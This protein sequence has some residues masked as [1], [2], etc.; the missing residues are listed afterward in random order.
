MMATRILDP[1][2]AFPTSIPASGIA[3]RTRTKTTG[4]LAAKG[5]STTG[6]CTIGSSIGTSKAV[7][8]K[9]RESEPPLPHS[10]RPAA[11]IPLQHPGNLSALATRRSVTPS[12]AGI[13][14]SATHSET[15]DPGPQRLQISRPSASTSSLVETTPQLHTMKTRVA[16]RDKSPHRF[17]IVPLKE[18]GSKREQVE[19]LK[20]GGIKKETKMV[21]GEQ[22]NA[23]KEN[24]VRELSLAVA[25]SSRNARSSGISPAIDSVRPDPQLQLIPIRSLNIVKLP[26]KWTSRSGA[27][28]VKTSSMQVTRTF[29]SEASTYFASSAKDSG[30]RT[31]TL[32]ERDPNIPGLSTLIN[33]HTRSSTAHQPFTAPNHE[34]PPNYSSC[35][36]CKP[37]HTPSKG[38]TPPRSSP[39]CKSSSLGVVQRPVWSISMTSPD[40]PR[41][42]VDSSAPKLAPSGKGHT[43]L[44]A[45]AAAI[46]RRHRHATAYSVD[47]LNPGGGSNITKFSP[48]RSSC[49]IVTTSRQ[50]P[51]VRKIFGAPLE[52]H[53]EKDEGEDDSATQALK[54]QSTSKRHAI[55]SRSMITTSPSSQLKNT[56]SITSALPPAFIPSANSG[57]FDSILRAYQ[58][59]SINTNH[60]SLNLVGLRS[61]ARSALVVPLALCKNRPGTCDSGALPG[62]AL[63]HLPIIQELLHAVDS[64]LQDWNALKPM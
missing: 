55:Y 28:K 30:R 51:D 36:P 26:A 62:R 45:A 47:A 11:K 54:R 37:P 15:I 13:P 23:G 60:S 33:K 38:A 48:S 7:R 53:T 31:R 12:E 2:F 46:K 9:V 49:S 20:A 57:S 19:V 8:K 39:H 21:K 3:R 14:A 63:V 22:R 5:P 29:S 17:Q 18:V 58:S 16:V 4:S 34:F 41:H 27:G 44:A 6:T 40:T 59:Q 43:S 24:T 42:T 52:R 64:A 50:V 25:S 35:K 56:Q 1:N 10:L 61:S 32:S